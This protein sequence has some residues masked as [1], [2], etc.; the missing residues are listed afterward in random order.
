M[1]VIE[2]A[3]AAL[4]IDPARIAQVARNHGVDTQEAVEKIA[5][6]RS[7]LDRGGKAAAQMASVVLGRD[8]KGLSRA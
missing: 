5:Y 8:V 6:R 2:E 4:D 7:V 1:T 3:R